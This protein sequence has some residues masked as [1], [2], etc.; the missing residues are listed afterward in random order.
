[1]HEVPRYNSKEFKEHLKLANNNKLLAE[2]S[3][4]KKINLENNNFG[5]ERFDPFVD[6]QSSGAFSGIKPK[7]ESYVIFKE[8]LLDHGFG[9]CC[10][11]ILTSL[12]QFWLLSTY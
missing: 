7:F 8:N 10:L 12:I 5:E 1:M 11:E 9:S 6:P 3:M 4:E 2:F